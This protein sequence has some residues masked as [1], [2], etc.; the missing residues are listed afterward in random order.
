MICVFIQGCRAFF[1]GIDV[2]RILRQGG[3]S[4]TAA[5]SGYFCTAV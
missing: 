3:L 2:T 1:A 4:V 5:S